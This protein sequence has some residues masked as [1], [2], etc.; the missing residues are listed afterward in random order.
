MTIAVNKKNLILGVGNPLRRDDGVG[1]AVISQLRIEAQTN[2]QLANVDIIDGG[3]DG[4]ALLDLIQNYTD[5]T[6]IDAVEMG[7]TPGTVKVFTP[8][9][10]TINISSDALSTHGFGL[11]EVLKLMEELAMN[12]KVTV[13]GIQPKDITFGEGLS[14]EVADSLNKIVSLAIIS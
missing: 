12:V 6:I 2:P 8:T 5:V 14:D 4:L 7:A 10:A 9:D 1:P 11:A 3:I 13:I